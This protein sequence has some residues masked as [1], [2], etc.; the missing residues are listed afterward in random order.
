MGWWDGS[1]SKSTRLLFRRSGV[2]IPAT[3]WWLTTICNKIW[4]PLLECL[5]TATVYLHII[6]KYLKKKSIFQRKGPVCLN[7][8]PESLWPSLGLTPH[9]EAK[10]FSM[11]FLSAITISS[12]EFFKF[13]FNLGSR[14]KTFNVP[15]PPRAPVLGQNQAKRYQECGIRL[16]L[17]LY[18]Q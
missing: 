1:V 18:I 7:M 9:K 12:S 15:P 11:H 6:N 4:L 17:Y 13:I 16:F 5:K 10:L 3:T 8:N 14:S 2:Q